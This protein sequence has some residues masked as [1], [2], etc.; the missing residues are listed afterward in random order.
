MHVQKTNWSTVTMSTFRRLLL[1]LL[2]L[3]IAQGLRSDDQTRPLLTYARDCLGILYVSQA[4]YRLYGD[5]KPPS[6]PRDFAL[7]L[8]YIEDGEIKTLKTRLPAKVKELELDIAD[9]A[10]ED[11][12]VFP[13][14]DA[15]NPYWWN[16]DDDDLSY[17]LAGVAGKIM[18]PA[19]RAAYL[20]NLH[21]L[22]HAG[23]IA[24]DGYLDQLAA[25]ADDP[26]P[27]IAQRLADLL[28]AFRTS[29]VPDEL[30]PAFDA[31]VKKTMGAAAGKM[32]GARAKK[33]ERPFSQAPGYAAHREKWQGKY[34]AH[35]QRFLERKTQN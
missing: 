33:L 14:V 20:E 31:Y 21:A 8:R 6:A 16:I 5:P 30:Q 4:P 29:L 11:G 17:R 9:T 18:S 7:A 28:G 34:L 1:P 25:F 26:S 22:L 12:W 24:G 23:K 35:L 13:V 32:D 10:L 27:E 3:S 19:E 15:A 2:S